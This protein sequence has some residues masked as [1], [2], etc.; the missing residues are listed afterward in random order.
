MTCYEVIDTATGKVVYWHHEKA[1]ADS[2]ARN[3]NR[4]QIE[5]ERYVVTIT[6]KLK[7]L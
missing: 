7:E 5:P 1:W 4:V 2:W 3:Q 6:Y